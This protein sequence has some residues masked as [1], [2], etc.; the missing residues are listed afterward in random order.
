MK[1]LSLQWRITLMTALLISLTCI[2]LNSLIYFS[3][4]IYIN[5]LGSYVIELLPFGT[6]DDLS[7]E[8]WETFYM[9]FPEHVSET[10][11]GFRLNSW[12]ITLIVTLFSSAVAYFVTGKAL[13]P[14]RQFS[15][16]MKEIQVLNLSD[17]LLVKN[18]YDEIGE[19]THSFN[20]ML[21]RLNKAFTVQR[22]FTGNAAHELRT[23][24]AVIQAK[25]D[26]YQ[27]L[28]QPTLEEQSETMDMIREQTKRL[29]DLVKVLLDM[30]E[31][32]TIQRADHISLSELVEE[33]IF[34]LSHLAEKKQV[35]LIQVEGN[36]QI[37]GSDILIYR[38]VYNLVENA[39]KYNLP[40]GSVSVEVTER[41]TGN[42]IT[43]SDT[44]CGICIKNQEEVFIPFFRVDQSRSRAMGGAGLGLALVR[45]I[46]EL[47]GGT[48]RVVQSSEAG[49]EI[50][51]SIP[52]QNDNTW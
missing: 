27:K 23:P 26:V 13:K 34:D 14:L 39:I 31:L 28:E 24:L 29:S 38:A 9:D 6:A 45:E 52:R 35:S 11:Q 12:F 17:P 4:V 48:V 30:T 33:V 41:E 8:E 42:I 7:Y 44:G 3:S 43:V 47:H 37:T 32:Q 22:Q 21:E 50:E 18:Q 2:V 25:M 5:E 15:T 36:A 40:G 1:K 49:T 20:N 19:L 46:A 16:Q 51:L 10:K